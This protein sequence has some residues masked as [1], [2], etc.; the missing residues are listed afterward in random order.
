MFI[1]KFEY[2]KNLVEYV[3]TIKKRIWLNDCIEW[4][5]PNEAYDDFILECQRL[6]YTVDINN[7]ATAEIFKYARNFKLKFSRYVNKMTDFKKLDKNVEYDK[8]NRTFK[9]KLEVLPELIILLN[10]D[11]I[12]CSITEDKIEDIHNDASNEEDDG[13]ILKESNRPIKRLKS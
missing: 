6:G 4:M 8:E 7:Q 2:D 10:N 12:Q 13:P 5:L 11:H 1:V 3:Q 9:F